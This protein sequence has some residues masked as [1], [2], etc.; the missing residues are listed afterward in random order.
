MFCWHEV[1]K[2]SFFPVLCTADVADDKRSVKCAPL[3]LVETGKHIHIFIY[4]YMYI[5]IRIYVY[6]YVKRAGIDMCLCVCVFAYT[7]GSCVSL[8]RWRRVL[9]QQRLFAANKL[10]PQH[11]DGWKR[12]GSTAV[13]AWGDSREVEDTGGG[14]RPLAIPLRFACRK[15]GARRGSGFF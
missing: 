14:L 2:L 7:Y 12:A 9:L 5:Y 6:T 13:A 15:S 4:I 11:A 3:V 10:L 8:V 1:E